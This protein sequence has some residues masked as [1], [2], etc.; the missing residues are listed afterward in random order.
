MHD[1]ELQTRN[2]GKERMIQNDMHESKE[3]RYLQVS[4]IVL[5]LF[6]YFELMA[7]A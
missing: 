4:V 5:L 7:G 3:L 2:K 1:S 6:I